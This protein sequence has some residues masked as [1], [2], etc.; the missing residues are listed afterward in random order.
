MAIELE[1]PDRLEAFKNGTYPRQ[2]WEQDAL[3]KV[4][5]AA[6][7]IRHA[8]WSSFVAVAITAVVAIAI[9][10]SFGKVAFE[11]PLSWPKLFSLLGGFLAAWATLMELGG[12]I[13]T[14]SGQTLPEL[15]HPVFFRL[16]FI[17][18]TLLV[19]V[20]LLW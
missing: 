18:G 9:A 10:F 20:G 4:N 17:P 7:I 5:D 13:K 16:L 2:G 11:L 14:Y 3:Q 15:I 19:M 1:S 6:D 12:F 8:I